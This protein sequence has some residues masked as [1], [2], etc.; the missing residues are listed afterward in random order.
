MPRIIRAKSM[1]FCK[2][3]ER[4]VDMAFTLSRD[5]CIR[6]SECPHRSAIYTIGP[7][8]HNAAVLADLRAGGINVLDEADLEEMGDDAI[9]GATVIIRAHGVRPT[10][11]EKLRHLGAEIADATCPKVRQNQLKAQNLVQNNGDLAVLFIVG[12]EKH[13]EVQGLLG[14]AKPKAHGTCRVIVI[15]A[16]QEATLAAKSLFYENPH[17]KTAIIAQ[18]TISNLI[19][20]EICI[21]IKK[22]FPALEVFNTICRATKDRQDALAQL[23]NDADDPVDAVIIAGD[24]ASSN[25]RRLQNIAQDCGKPAFIASSPE[26]IPCSIFAYKTIGLSAGA[27]T[28]RTVIDAIERGLTKFT[29]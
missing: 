23:C 13:A 26:D 21:E 20:D 2:G 9:N 29:G 3:V 16:L 25:T 12:E 22:F 10:V 17:R 27:S 6:G 1:G 4:A 8:I 11:Y 28:P 19:F 18:T 24:K 5:F 14:F 15:S 7:L